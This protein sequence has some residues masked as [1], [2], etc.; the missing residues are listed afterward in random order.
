[1][2]PRYIVNKYWKFGGLITIVVGTLVW[3]ATASVETSTTYFKTIPEVKA[4]KS[5]KRLRVGGW[6]EKGSIIRG[7]NVAF[8]IEYKG[9]KLPVVYTGVDPL[10][11]TF[12]DGSEALAEG[13][14]GPDGTFHASKIQAK[15]ASKYGAKPGA[16]GPGDSSYGKETE[17]KI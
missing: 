1:M 11:D 6:V 13:K 2:L 8:T 15:C 17:K 10:P 16:V 3:I 9:E 5:T 14:M 7:A 12:K 4:E